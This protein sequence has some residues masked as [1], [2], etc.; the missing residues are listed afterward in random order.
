[1]KRKLILAGLVLMMVVSVVATALAVSNTA[2][3]EDLLRKSGKSFALFEDRDNLWY[4]KVNS[5]KLGEYEVYVWA[6]K[7]SSYVTFYTTVFSLDD[8]PTKAFLWRLL[9]YNDSMVG[10][11]YVI[12]DDD[13]GGYLVDCQIDL[14]TKT[15]TADDIKTVLS[16]LVTVIDDSY[17]DLDKLL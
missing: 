16:D 3:V 15:L 14:P 12:R 1:M 5:Q 11:K 4:T 7:S 9:E 6:R 17:T 10:F 2:M 8:E 13:E